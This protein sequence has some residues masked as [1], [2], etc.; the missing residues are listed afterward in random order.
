MFFKKYYLRKSK[1]FKVENT[2]KVK[3]N[4]GTTAFLLLLFPYHPIFF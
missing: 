2:I 1:M 3:V 4:E